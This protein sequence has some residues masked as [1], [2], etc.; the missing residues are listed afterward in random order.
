M[1]EDGWKGSFFSLGKL[2]PFFLFL[3]FAIVYL[4]NNVLFQSMDFHEKM[5]L[6]G[7]AVF[8]ILVAIVYEVSKICN[9]E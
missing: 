3:I 6:L 4:G 8:F 2:N 7:L 1:N 9:E 5:F